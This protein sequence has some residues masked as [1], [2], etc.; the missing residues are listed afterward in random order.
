MNGNNPRKLLSR[1]SENSE[2]NIK[3][4]LQEKLET[5]MRHVWKHQRL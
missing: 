5:K 3:V 2:M 4:L 1:I